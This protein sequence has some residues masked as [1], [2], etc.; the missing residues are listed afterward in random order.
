[1]G[2]DGRSPPVICLCNLRNCHIIAWVVRLTRLKMIIEAVTIRCGGYP[3]RKLRAIVQG[4]SATFVTSHYA[5][6][7]FMG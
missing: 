4:P 7:G 1:M 3:D 6:M 2:N 5:N